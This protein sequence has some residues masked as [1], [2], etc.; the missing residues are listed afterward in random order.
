MSK[1]VGPGFLAHSAAKASLDSFV[2]TLATELG[3]EG[4]RVN[5]VAPGLILT[6][7]TANL[8]PHLKAAAAARCP[9]RRNGLPRDVAGAVLFLAS[10]L[11]Y[12]MT[13]GYLAIDGGTTM[14]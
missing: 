6:D 8:S 3:P 2:R 5:T 11:S 12:F 14:L 4:I 1:G 10:D 9:L 7:S 13:G